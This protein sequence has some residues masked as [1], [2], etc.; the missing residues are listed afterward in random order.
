MNQIQQIPNNYNFDKEEMSFNDVIKKIHEL[1]II[2]INEWKL[3]VILSSVGL[4]IGFFYAKQIPITYTA[5]ITYVIEDNKPID[6]NNSFGGIA[7]QFG[8]GGVQ[9]NGGMF[10]NLQDLITSRFLIENTLLKPVKTRDG[11]ITNLA[12]Y[13]I[14]LKKEKNLNKITNK[15]VFFEINANRE[16]LSTKQV[17]ALKEIYLD[18]ISPQKLS[19]SKKDSKSFFSIISVTGEDEY[20]TKILCENIL[21][22]TSEF[23]IESKLKKNKQNVDKLQNQVDSI[24]NKFDRSLLTLAVAND[25]I[26]NLNPSLKSR[27][28][29]PSKSQINVQANTSL[30]TT[31]VSNLELAKA[32]LYNETPLFQIIDKPILPL[33]KNSPNKLKLII[34]SGIM[35]MLSAIVFII[36]KSFI[37]K[38][39]RSNP[40]M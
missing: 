31:L 3:I 35:A 29:E 34:L 37:L 6:Q 28:V 10:S 17:I 26:F 33:T 38:S 16:L 36:V 11:Q 12:N 39:I 32:N 22:A 2:I 21:Q 1:F 13:Y 27:G 25:K 40:K 4:L 9:A 18:L 19:F 15:E 23:Y 8:F 7:S 24:K 20:F 5:E 30:L 14:K